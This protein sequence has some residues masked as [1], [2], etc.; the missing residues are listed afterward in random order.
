MMLQGSSKSWSPRR[1]A[2]EPVV[3][4]ADVMT[5]TSSCP[6][7]LTAE[8]YGC[9]SYMLMSRKSAGADRVDELVD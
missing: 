5:A 8:P 4:R 2:P 6:G 3:P 1:T 7:R 9:S